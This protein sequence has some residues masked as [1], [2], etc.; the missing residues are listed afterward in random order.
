MKSRKKRRPGGKRYKEILYPAAVIGL[1]YGVLFLFGITCPI[2]FI[3]GVSCPGCGMTRAWLSVL[4]LDFAAAFHYHP[5]FMVP[6]A[7]IVI[8]FLKPVM[9]RNIYRGVMLTFAG[10]FG[11]IYLCRLIYAG[12]DV[13]VFQPENNI[14]FRLFGLK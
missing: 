8:Y 14:I 7:A 5:L 2:K 4:R 12:G 1:F 10:A 6:P 13:V 3:T 9:N 11:I